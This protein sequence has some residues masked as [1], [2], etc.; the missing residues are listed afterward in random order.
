MYF[1]PFTHLMACFPLSIQ[2]PQQS[3]QKP[4]QGLSTSLFPSNVSA[5]LLRG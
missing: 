3:T 1:L 5:R 2:K 4:E